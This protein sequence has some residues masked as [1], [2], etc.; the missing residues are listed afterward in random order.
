MFFPRRALSRNQPFSKVFGGAVWGCLGVVLG[1]VPKG[2]WGR[3]GVDLGLF[4]GCFG[5]RFGFGVVLGLFRGCFGVVLGLFW[6]CFGVRQ[7]FVRQTLA[8]VAV[9]SACCHVVVPTQ[10]AATS[11]VQLDGRGARRG[12][13]GGEAGQGLGL[14]VGSTCV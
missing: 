9:W 7:E 6:G 3:F 10:Q 2:V 14:E 5:V 11:P 4:W 12:C 1:F 13:G 8:F